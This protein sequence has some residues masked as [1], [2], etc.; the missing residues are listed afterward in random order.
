M[1]LRN[2]MMVAAILAAAISCN[3][4]NGE[5]QVPDDK[6]AIEKTYITLNEGE[7]SSVKLI[8]SKFDRGIFVSEDY[9]FETNPYNLRFISSDES[10][11]TVS[12][13][14]LIEAIGVGSSQITA[15]A[16]IKVNGF[17][18]V[19]VKAKE[20]IKYTFKAD[21]ANTKLTEENIVLPLG[22]SHAT[23]QSF[24]MDRSGNI[25]ISWEEDNAMHVRKFVGGKPVGD[26]MILPCSGHGDCFCIEQ[27][28]S[29]CYFWTT[30]SLGEPSGGFSGGKAND[31]AVRFTCRFKFEAGTVKYPEDAEEC[32]YYSV[33]GCR[34]CDIDLEH[35]MIAF[36]GGD[37]S[38]DFCRI[39]KFSDLKK[40]SKITKK[41]TR[42]HNKGTE[43]TAY[44]LN[45]L[46]P[47]GSFSF[48]RTI[49]C[50][51]HL[52]NGESKVNAVQGFTV[53]DGKIYFEA[54]YKND[55]AST[56]TVLDFSGTILQE[57]IPVGL[58]ADKNQLKSLNLSSDGTFEP[59]G[60]HIRKGVMYFGF[61]GDYPTNGAKKH[62]C[63]LK[64]E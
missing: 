55:A 13:E 44:N 45:S 30:G 34:I 29:E 48:T 10:V 62:S 26:D 5:E 36:W 59:E 60:I 8:Y 32:Y 40:A 35:D 25:Y 47:V 38:T 33:N 42:E 37:S 18:D 58:S 4:G 20:E 31:S 11:A 9:D 54:G 6:L 41:V 46:S 24:D 53:Y 3:K 56:V 61:V 64:I 39:Y 16:D 19:T 28:K 50:G 14:G 21:I 1:K 57:R 7:T 23:M 15:K 27:D 43:V 52:D 17:V 63:I 2:F 49:V 12:P 51:T 22:I